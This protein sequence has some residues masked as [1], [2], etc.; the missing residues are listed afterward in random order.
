MTGLIQRRPRGRPP[1]ARTRVLRHDG[2]LGVH[3]FAFLRSWFLGLDLRH[4]WQRYLAFSAMSDDLRHIE[5]RRQALLHQVLDA[6]QQLNLD[7]PPARQITAQLALL[8]Q[9]PFDAGST[10]LPSLDEFV[11][12]QGLDREFYSESELLQEYRQFFHLDGATDSAPPETNAERGLGQAQVRA[13]NQVEALLARQPEAG[14]RLD[15]WLSPALAALLRTAGIGTLGAL[16]DT[17]RVYGRRWHARARGLGERRAAALVAWLGPLA[18]QFGHAI[19]SA[20]LD[21]SRHRRPPPAAAPGQPH[22]APRFALVPLERLAVPAHL[23]GG[24]GLAAPAGRAVPASPPSALNDLQALRAW[25]SQPRPDATRRAYTKEAER[26]YLWCLHARGKPLAAIDVADCR[27]YL[28]FLAAPPPEWVNARPAARTD[29]AWRPLRG[30]LGGASLNFARVVVQNLFD[31]L[32]ASGHLPANPMRALARQRTALPRAPALERAFT[33]AEWRFVMGQLDRQLLT[34]DPTDRGQAEARRIA[35]LLHLLSATGL[36]LSEIAA[37]TLADLRLRPPSGTRDLALG[38]EAGAEEGP[39]ADM[40]LGA[41]WL[42]RVQSRHGG[43]R[44]LPLDAALHALI[45]R[46]HEDAAA[47]ATLPSPPP[48]VCTLAERPRRWIDGPDGVVQ[49]SPQ[50]PP[51]IRA[52]GAAGVYLTLKRFFRRIAADAAAV[53]GLSRERLRAASTHWLRHTFGREA[54]AA[55]MPLDALRRALGHASLAS[56]GRYLGAEPVDTS[57][58]LPAKPGS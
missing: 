4:A 9:P 56:T 48:I 31:D 12:A 44:E 25:L 40:A 50:Q 42:I 43:A 37:A 49:L 10:P 34:R 47:I 16:A 39:V 54:V 35:L 17:V 18:E 45:A 1:G 38:P 21:P 53:D 5:H 6:G 41:G 11:D 27:S 33:E 8:A 19:P 51:T 55:G 24:A 36:R 30:P 3:H 22:V 7:L 32:C 15:L 26:F 58:T 57:A 20:V 29:P 13:L 2:A 28:D 14:D 23:A 52:L 46:H